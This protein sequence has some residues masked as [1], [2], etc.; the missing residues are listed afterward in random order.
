MKIE[1]LPRDDHQIKLVAEMEPELLEKFM[2]RAARKI[3]QEAK[4]PGF[5]PGKAPYDVV[6][7]LYGDEMIQKQAVELML[8]EIYP[9]AIQEANIQPAGPGQLEE[10]VSVNPPKF[11]FIVP[12]MPEV[13]LADYHQIRK[14]YQL[15]AVGEEEIQK[16]IRN[17]QNNYATAEPVERPAEDGDLV[18]ALIAASFAEPEEGQ[19]AEFIRETP[20]Q[21]VVGSKEPGQDDWPF[22]GFSK[23]LIGMSKDE[24]KSV[25]Y[26]YPED[27]P[28]EKLQG[29]SVNFTIKLQGVKSMQY[30]ELDDEFAKSVGEFET[31]DELNK[32][33]V[34]ELETQHQKEYDDKYLTDLIDSIVEQSVIKYPPVSLEEEQEHILHHLEEDLS[35][36]KMD[37]A[38]Y[39]K[40]RQL[41]QE[42]FI[43]DEIKPV[44]KKRL[45]RSLVLDKLAESEKIELDRDELQTAVTHTL[46]ELQSA[47]DYSKFKTRQKMQ[48]LT[49]AVAYETANRL[50][51]QRLMERLKAIATGTFINEDVATENQQGTLENQVETDSSNETANTPAENK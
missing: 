30:P 49:N 18:Y 32:A 37:I 47:P 22:Q 28:F 34:T 42:K 46:M 51:N 50:I 40:I 7:R 17:L 14:E 27:A 43:E 41:E 11:S 4:V 39:L 19:E 6:K 38:T 2:R 1:T 25:H 13:E 24:E 23:E 8:D 3:S 12:L 44:A 29:K 26:T 5:R 48:N 35:K 16:V 10:I 36:Q 20:Y 33:I 9:E 45:E 21:I 31:M 15:E